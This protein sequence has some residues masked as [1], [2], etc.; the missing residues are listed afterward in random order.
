M[1]WPDGR[2]LARWPN[3]CPNEAGSWQRERWLM[4][5]FESESVLVKSCKLAAVAGHVITSTERHTKSYPVQIDTWSVVV[6]GRLQ[7]PF[8]TSH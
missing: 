3:V 5:I 1:N 6:G 7:T 8:L 4:A 2:E